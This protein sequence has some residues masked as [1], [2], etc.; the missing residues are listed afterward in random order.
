M[1]SRTSL[2]TTSLRVRTV[3]AI[4]PISSDY[5]QA[6]SIPV[7]GQ[8]GQLQWRQPLPFLNAITIPTVGCT[9]LDILQTVQPGISTMSTIHASTVRTYLT[10]TVGGLGGSLYVSTTYLNNALN[11]LSLTNGWYISSTTLY[12]VVASLGNLARIGTLGPIPNATGGSNLSGGYVYTANA[13][14][15]TRYQSSL[16]GGGDQRVL[17]LMAG[18]GQAGREINIATYQSKFL[19]TSKLT[20]DIFTGTSVT[21]VTAGTSLSTFLFVT[22]TGGILPATPILVGDPVIYTVPTGMTSLSIPSVRFLLQPSQILAAGSPASVTIG[23]RASAGAT[24]QTNIPT[25]GGIFVT[26]DNTD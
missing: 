5:I 14:L 26:L 22:G 4:N 24:V 12:E 2:D 25:I 7:I 3:T 21:G 11:N 1:S 13:G 23:Y 9:T 6:E 17:T 18:I 8:Q 15:Y 16:G 20:F 10:S 19:N